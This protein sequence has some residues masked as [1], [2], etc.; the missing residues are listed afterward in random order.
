[1]AIH[2]SGVLTVPTNRLCDAETAYIE[3]DLLRH[4]INHAMVLV[5]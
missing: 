1:M 2:T 3:L 4:S 5:L